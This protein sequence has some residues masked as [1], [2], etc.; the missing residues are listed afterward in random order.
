MMKKAGILLI[1]LLLA[2]MSVMAEES[3]RITIN[4][5]IETHRDLYVGQ[6]FV[7]EVVVENKNDFPVIAEF[8]KVV[9]GVEYKKESITIQPGNKEVLPYKIRIVSNET[10]NYQIPVIVRGAEGQGFVMENS[11]RIT[12]TEIRNPTWYELLAQKWQY[13]LIGVLVFIGGT[14]YAIKKSSKNASDK[15][16]VLTEDG[17]VIEK[18]SQ[19]E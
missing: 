15:E 7:N 10:K 17:E 13:L 11:Q 2:S 18:D 16:T 19:E 8:S 14:L 12:L 6:N 1:M 5:P 3:L 4:N 9:E